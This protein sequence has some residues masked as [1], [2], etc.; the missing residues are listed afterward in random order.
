MGAGG[1][2][3]GRDPPAPA[4]V[5]VH[6]CARTR[7]T[8]LFLPGR[9]VV[10]K[11]PL[12]ADADRRLRHEL[13]MLGRLGGV[14][15]VAQLVDTPRYPGSVVLADV[16]GSSLAG[17]VM[18]LD[19]AE[20]IVLGLGLARAVAGMHGRGVLHRDITPSNIVICEDG[21]PLL[22][23]FALATSFA[24][25]RPEFTHTARSSGRW[26]ISLLS[27]PGGRGGRW[28]SGL[29]CMRWVRR[30]MSWRRVIRR[31]VPVIRCVSP[32][33]TWPGC[34]WRRPW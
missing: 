12:G 14:A 30:C 15:G 18:P 28:I 6:E 32:T 17:R 31:S 22:V 23:D 2:Q 19:I 27:R 9:T 25:I 13:A 29:I 4:E 26:L 3:P 11:E 24:E 5:L 7:V 16:G 33:I 34:R 21:G 10:R 20:L 8:R 1:V